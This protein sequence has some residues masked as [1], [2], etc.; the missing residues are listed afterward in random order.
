MQKRHALLRGGDGGGNLRRG[1]HGGACCHNI[2]AVEAWQ[3]TLCC[4]YY[5][6]HGAAGEGENEGEVWCGGRGRQ[7]E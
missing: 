2:L 3:E 4:G 5:C 7:G 6:L 1:R